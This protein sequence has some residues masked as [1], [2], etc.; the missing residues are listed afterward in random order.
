MANSIT[1]SGS[2]L[3][4]AHSTDPNLCRVSGY[5]KNAMGQPLGGWHFV[6]RYC[7][8][9][10]GLYVD[11]L[12]AQERYTIR[13]DRNGYVEFDVIRGSRFTL[14]LPNNLP[15]VYKELTGPD[16][17]S[18]D[19]LDML[20]PRIVSVDFATPSSESILVGEAVSSVARA[21]LSNGE[22]ITLPTA[23]LTVESSNP[24]VLDRVAPGTYRGVSPGYAE[25]SITSVDADSA[26]LNQDKEENDLIF[27]DKPAPT[28]PSSPKSVTVS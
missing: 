12:V 15:W 9:P 4:N 16:A 11:T 13:A 22:V 5:L 24:S 18:V 26:G 8:V 7:Y 25:L 19:L 28:L 14:E 17:A 1:L 6:L 3:P 27:F 20:F 21:T 23:A 2:A 10:L